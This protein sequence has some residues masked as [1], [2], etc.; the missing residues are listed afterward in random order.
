VVAVLLGDLLLGE[1]ITPR[2][3]LGAGT[4]I[5]GVFLAGRK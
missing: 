4:V 3:L 1:N 5:A 2:V